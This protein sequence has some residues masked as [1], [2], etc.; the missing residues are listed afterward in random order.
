L[1]KQRI[2]EVLL[3]PT[4]REIEFMLNSA[5]VF[6]ALSLA[7]AGAVC[8]LSGCENNERQTDQAVAKKI[9]E[10][11]KARLKATDADQLSRVQA[12]Y[13]TLAATQ[14]LSAEMKTLVRGRQGE[15]RM[16]RTMMLLADL[17]AKELTITRS[18]NDLEQLALQLAGAQMRIEALNKFDPAS[19]IQALQAQEADIRGGAD[20]PTW[21]VSTGG[22]AAGAQIPTL[23]KLSSDIDALNAGIDKNKSDVA[24][25]TK[26]SHDNLDQADVVSRQAEG[27]TGDRQSQD[28]IKALELRR[29]S[30]IADA[31]LDTLNSRLTHLQARLAAA[32]AQKAAIDQAVASFESQISGLQTGWTQIQQQI[33]AQRKLEQGLIAGPENAQPTDPT[34][35]VTISGKLEELATRLQDAAALRETVNKELNSVIEQFG[36]ASAQAEKLRTDLLADSREHPNDPD[37]VIW[38]QLMLTLHPLYYNL[39]MA[40]AMESRASVAAGKTGIDIMIS[41]MMDGS[42]TQAAVKIPGLTELLRRDRTGVDVPK[43]LDDIAKTDQDQLKQSED[44]VNADFQKTLAA[45]DKRF[46]GTDSREDMQARLKIAMIGRSVANREWAQFAAMVG[47]T[48]AQKEHLRDADLDDSQV[49]PSASSAADAAAAAARN[50]QAPAPAAAPSNQ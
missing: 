40:D 22:A 28:T 29:D 16:E 11:E 26:K 42:P 13:D 7:L 36:D 1:R 44:E 10:V 20:K 4:L 38:Q 33:E 8:L 31:Q 23:A 41:Q 17:R 24:A 19:Q 15:L 2:C 5:K 37:G 47:D 30:E 35:V 18:I 32:Q 27:E 50:L 46:G 9:E 49:D 14:G 6:T 25:L 48:D 45:Y 34:A 3:A 43:S 21:T 12:Q 39:Q